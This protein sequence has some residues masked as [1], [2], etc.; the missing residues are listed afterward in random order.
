MS[1]FGVGTIAWA[2]ALVAGFILVFTLGSPLPS[3]GDELQAAYHPA[4]PVTQDA[5]QASAA[6]IVRLEYPNL[7]PFAPTVTRQA[8]F[9]IDAWL[10]VYAAGG[11]VPQGVQISVGVTTGLVEVAAFP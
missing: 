4:T 6:T 2:A 8:T 11:D 1:R 3:E 5:A 7:V 10:L 9:G